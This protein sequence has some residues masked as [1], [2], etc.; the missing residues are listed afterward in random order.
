[1]NRLKPRRPV[2]ALLAL[3][4]AFLAPTD[5]RTSAA[6]DQARG[7]KVFRAGAAAIDITPQ[8]LPVIVNGG[9]LEG[10][11]AA[12]TDALYARCL[13]LDDG[14]VRIAI[15]VVDSCVIPR[16]ILDETKALAR[17]ATGIPVGRMLISATHCHSAPS[18]C[19]ALGSGVEEEYARWLPG[20][21]AEG[22]AR[23]QKNL[24]PARIG[25]AVGK[26]PK[27]V[28]C[29]RFLMKPGTAPTDPFSGTANDQAQMNPGYQNPSAIRRTGPVDDDVSVLSVQTPAGRP[30]A[31]VGNYSTHYAGAPPLSADYFG[32][33]CRRI[34][35]LVGAG[36]GAAEGKWGQAPGKTGDSPLFPRPAFVGIMSNGTSGDANCCDFVNP[37][38]KFDRFTVGEDVAQAAFEA[39][40][41]IQYFDWVPLAMEEKL[42]TLGVRMPSA[43]EVARAKEHL[44]KVPGGKLR[45]VTDVYARETVLLSDMP[46]TRELKLQAIRIGPLGIAAM[47]NEVFGSTGLA[48]KRDS[49]LRPTINIELA[50]GYFGYLPPP[51]QFPLGGYTTWRAR[52]SCLEVEAEPKV[53]AAELELLNRVAG[54][55]RDEQPVPSK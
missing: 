47:P 51:D 41:R 24:A 27:N 30:I 36:N 11:A 8:K 17:K 3:S 29:R 7:A 2:V 33:F 40:R 35:E 9:F 38:R 22:I 55:R 49:P 46:A 39:Y 43:E 42:L 44:A 31:L 4:M 18:V 37:P 12:V 21:I 48:I 1:M 32:V 23:A 5:S 28:F 34:G 19:G 13:V 53:R 14:T 54:Q 52:S 50:N 26:D 20:R 16:P 25:W 6:G 45:N 10:K 15:A